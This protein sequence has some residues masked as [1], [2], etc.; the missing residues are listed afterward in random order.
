M[1][2]NVMPPGSLINDGL[3]TPLRPWCKQPGFFVTLHPRTTSLNV[4]PEARFR[5]SYFKF[6]HSPYNKDPSIGGTRSGSTIFGNPHIG[7]RDIAKF[8]TT[9]YGRLRHEQAPPAF[10]TKPQNPGWTIPK[11]T[12]SGPVHNRQA[13]EEAEAKAAKENDLL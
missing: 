9:C 3:E 12:G 4:H 2:S 10:S 5:P 8:L 6:P 13:R 11:K 1:I 7:F